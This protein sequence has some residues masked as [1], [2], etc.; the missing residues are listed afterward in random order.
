MANLP[1]D[2][3]GPRCGA[4]HQ[5]GIGQVSEIAEADEFSHVETDLDFPTFRLLCFL[6]NA[7]LHRTSNGVHQFN[8]KIY[9]TDMSFTMR[10]A[11]ANEVK[12]YST[13]FPDPPDEPN[14]FFRHD[15]LNP[16]TGR[17]FAWI[18]AD[19]KTVLVEII[20]PS[21]K[22]TKSSLDL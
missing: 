16:Q 3:I 4:L 5:V 14:T 20:D 6:T 9:A 1:V 12:L 11:Q 17:T 22:T 18:P 13:T 15:P 10:S 2:V 19:W 8:L 21:G 7:P